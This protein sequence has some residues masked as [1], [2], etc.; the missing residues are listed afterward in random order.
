V[1]VC[2]NNH[3]YAAFVGAAVDSCLAQT[4]PRV[5]VVVVDD[6]STDDSRQVL[7]RYGSRIRTIYQANAGQS[8]AVNAG[9]A[10]ARGDVVVLLDADDLLL[11]DTVARAVAALAADDR[12]VRV[13]W[14]LELVD[15][16]GQRTGRTIPP[17]GWRLPTG[18]LSDVALRYRT[19]VWNPTSAS[20]YRRSAL[21]H[22]LPM[23]EHTYERNTGP[24]LYLSETV[25]LLGRVGALDGV[26]G[27]YRIHRS[28]Y[29][30]TSRQDDAV[31]L[32]TKVAEIVA[33]QQHVH[34][35]ARRLGR[36]VPT[37]PR[38]AKDWAFA[39][40]RLALLRVDPARPFAGDTVPSLVVHGVRS[41]LSHPHLSAVQRAKRAAWFLAMAVMPQ[42]AVRPVIARLLHSSP[43][44]RLAAEQLDA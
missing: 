13:Q 4:H 36:E 7:E 5:E 20:A 11:P 25:V 44:R 3:N 38:V 39:A 29:T 34:E 17:P 26:G 31:F 40:Y 24:D 27:Q 15:E 33:G 9:F 18:D 21:E 12:L 28:N 23:P 42:R 19:Y 22:V 14:L 16:Q 2:I 1:T 43:E 8:A 6:G 37:D 35:L 10:A 32:R 30:T 41:V